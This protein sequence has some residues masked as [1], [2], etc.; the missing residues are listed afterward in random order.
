VSEYKPEGTTY[1]QD[2][3]PPDADIEPEELLEITAGTL[4]ARASVPDPTDEILLSPNYTPGWPAGAPAG[5]T[6]HTMEGWFDPSVAWLRDPVSFASAHFCIRRDGK[7]VQLVWEHNRPWHARSSG[8]YYFGIVH[9]GG[10]GLGP[11]PMLWKTPRD[12]E[13]LREDD[14][15]LRQSARLVAY[16]CT[17]YGIYVQHDHTLPAARDTTSHIAGTDQMAGNDHVDPGPDF[18]WQAYMRRIHHLTDK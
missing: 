6:I 4:S 5:V 13:R 3:K 16:L 2:E 9:E 10:S 18:P 8:M 1:L 7:I 11:I 15:M 17:K 12:A 14:L